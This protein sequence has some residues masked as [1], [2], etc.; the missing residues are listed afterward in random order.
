MNDE[1]AKAATRAAALFVERDALASQL[2][3]LDDEIKHTTQDY[4]LAM[5]VWGF[6]PLMLRQA[7]KMRGLMK[8]AA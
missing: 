2:A 8:E 3:I 6:T 1:A 5:R 7:C 4:S